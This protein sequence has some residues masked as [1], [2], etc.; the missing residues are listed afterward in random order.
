MA[1]SAV[2]SRLSSLR[3][4]DPH[5][6]PA[7][8]HAVVPATAGSPLPTALRPLDVEIAGGGST[9]DLAAWLEETFATSL[10]VLGGGTVVHES[11][12]A[13]L[14]PTT[15][16]LG[17]SMT[18]SALAHLVGRAVAGGTLG[19]DD[20]VT[21]HVPELA[22][23]GWAGCRVLDVLTMTSGVDWVEDHRDPAS[24]ASQLLGAFAGGGDSRELLLGARTGVTPASR[25][26]YSTADSQVLDWVR[27]RATGRPFTADL[28]A[29]WAELGCTDDAHVA[30]DGRG[31]ALAGGGLAAT[32]RDWARLGLHAVAGAW[33][34]DTAR[35]AYA[36]TAPG[37]LPSTISAHVGFGRHWWPLD[38]RGDRV[39]A[40]GSRGQL[41]AV[42]RRTGAVVVKTSLWPYDDA[43]ADRSHR[44][45]SYLGLH[46]LL[47]ALDPDTEGELR[48]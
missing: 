20:P 33:A 19:V 47:D 12:A 43:W 31:V 13:G 44:D 1:A 22:A 25:W 15:R 3:F 46:A 30:V 14:G 28:A 11:Y 41:L 27:E 37:R 29:L 10:V 36:F 45:L 32:S 5:D 48:P 26:R 35:P 24:P 42:D 38:D 34:V 9:R 8:S 23:T 6:D 40:D 39:A 4:V 7:W 21:D 18:K 17:A 16:F 2:G